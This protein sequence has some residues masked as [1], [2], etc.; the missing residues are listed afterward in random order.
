M[1]PESGSKKN[2]VSRRPRKNHT[3]STVTS[4]RTQAEHADPATGSEVD[5]EGRARPGRR[6]VE[7]R[8]RAA[9]ELLAG[10]A[11][12]DQLARR[13]GV[14]PSTVEDWR[15]DA[16]AGIEDA[17]RRGTGKTASE[18]AME[19][20]LREL[21]EV[22]TTLSIQKCLLENALTAERGKRPTEPARSKR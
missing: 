6:S 4:T 14:L 11:T 8:N 1:D 2:I 7:D 16:L 21:E 15:D 19:R 17:L 5:G 3:A 20:K 12:V 22:V 9:L 13:L 18:L 10:K